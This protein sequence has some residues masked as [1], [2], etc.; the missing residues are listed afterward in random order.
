MQPAAALIQAYLATRYLVVVAYDAPSVLAEVKVGRRSA[1]MD[2]LLGIHGAR[3]GVFITA[4][5]PRSRPVDRTLNDAA[6]QR[7]EQELRRRGIRFLA[8][9]GAGADPAWEPEQGMFTLDLPLAQALGLAL[10]FGQNAI[11][12]IDHGGAAELVA[13]PL[14]EA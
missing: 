7:L 2:R 1:A 3:S 8:H 13:T 9:L 12:T 10:D 14:M 4:W 6:H 11:V 5:N